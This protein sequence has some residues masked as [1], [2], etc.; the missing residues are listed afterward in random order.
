MDGERWTLLLMRD[1]D[2]S[3]QRYG[4]P[5]AWVRTCIAAL[6]V[7]LVVL[8]AGVAYIAAQGTAE[9]RARGL[10]EENRV[11]TAELE[12][13]RGRVGQ[14][15][16]RMASLA[17]E[18]SRYR[19]LAGL[20]PIAPEILEV[21]VGGPGART[22]ESH[23]LSEANPETNELAFAVDYDLNALE[24]R[25]RLLTASLDEAADSLLAHRSLLESTPSILPTAGLVSSRFSRS[26]YHP[27]H[28]RPLPHEGVDIAADEGTPI[29][30]SARG[31][32]ET[33]EWRSGYGLLV[34]IDHGHG[35]QTRYGH[36][37][38]LLVREGQSVER[39]DVI[40]QVGATGI[41]TAPN[42]HYEVLVDG[43]PIDPLDYVLSESIP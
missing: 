37:S 27:I 25:A 39:G 21:G 1:G 5:S 41:A 9:L 35:F 34:E 28:H 33:A 38:E 3:V 14:L 26:R 31:R 7:L 42:L 40:A 30:A 43:E 4:V 19:T 22:P 11:L 16:N 17:D 24:R 20:D 8:V 32:V 23:P 10:A 13:M 2:P 12:E 6:V 29:L 18:S 36:A 15:E